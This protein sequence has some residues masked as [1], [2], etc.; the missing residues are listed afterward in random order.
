MFGADYFEE[1]RKVFGD[2]PFPYGLRTNAKAV[3]MVQTYSVEQGLTAKKQPLQELFA[4]EILAAEG[5]PLE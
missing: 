4:E 5:Y 1:Q 3:D 2:D